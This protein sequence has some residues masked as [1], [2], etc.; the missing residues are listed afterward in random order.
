VPYLSAA[1]RA[2]DELLRQGRAAPR[3]LA[4]VLFERSGGGLPTIVLGGFVPDSTEQVALLRGFFLRKGS[5]YYLN[6]ARGGFSLELLAAQLDDLVADLNTIHGRKPVV[7]SVSFGGGIALEW[8]RRV[9]A[10]GRIPGVAGLVFVSPVAC[11]ADVLETNGAKPA[12]LL[13]R[14]LK[15]YLEAGAQRDPALVERS[16]VI[17][18]RMFEAGA[19][20]K[21]SLKG[22]MGKDELRRLRAAVLGAIR[23]I[24]LVGAHERVRALGEMSDI[25]MWSASGVLPLSQAP[26]LI[27]FAEREGAVMTEGSPTRAALE[28]SRE[29]FFSNSECRV[30]AGGGTPVQHASLIFHYFQFQPHIAAFYRL[31]KT[32]KL[33]LAA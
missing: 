20:N 24:D 13:G 8:L 15:P 3:Q 33:R 28:L 32:G 17:F 23:E 29:A 16:R 14:A 11:A 2:R 4:S 25:A 7:F 6:Y 10:E 22:L 19:H 27:L 30:V 18:S 31:L 5:V 1:T 21:A 26:T 9:R 12:T